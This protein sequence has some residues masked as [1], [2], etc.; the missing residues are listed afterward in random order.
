MSLSHPKIYQHSD[1][2]SCAV[3]GKVWDANDMDPPSC[4]SPVPD[5]LKPIKEYVFQ[6]NVAWLVTQALVG[7]DQPATVIYASS[8]Y[9]AK[10][11]VRRVVGFLDGIEV[12]RLKALDEYASGR[13]PYF[14]IN[15]RHLLVAAKAQRCTVINL[16]QFKGMVL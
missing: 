7:P 15:P 2:F 10:D 5:A 6:T 11:Y 4:I 12:S 8:N 13:A 1:Q 9:E 14:E 16:R 3:C